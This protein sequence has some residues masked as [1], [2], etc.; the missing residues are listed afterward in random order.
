MEIKQDSF[1]PKGVTVFQTGRQDLWEAESR[2]EG[3]SSG[4]GKGRPPQGEGTAVDQVKRG[5][6]SRD[7]ERETSQA[8]IRNPSL[9]ARTLILGTLGTHGG[10]P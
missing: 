1:A 7:P 4:R 5:G 6:Q 2:A 8:G 3:A 9:R 10:D